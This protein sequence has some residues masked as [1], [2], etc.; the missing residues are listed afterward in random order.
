MRP[1][2]PHFRWFK[3]TRK[4]RNK[5]FYLLIFFVTSRKKYNAFEDFIV[6]NSAALLF[7][8]FAC[9]ICISLFDIIFLS[10]EFFKL[11][12]VEDFL[13]GKVW[14]PEKH[15]FGIL[16]VL[17]G[18]LYISLIAIAFAFPL[19][20]FSAVFL[21]VYSKRRV[22]NV[23]KTILEIIAGIPTI[24]LGFFASFFILP[25]LLA[26]CDTFG[27]QLSL[28]NAI[29]PGIAIGFMTIPYLTTLIDDAFRNV[30]DTLRYAGIALGISRAELMSQI[31]MRVAMPSIINSIIIAISRVL[32]ETMIVVISCGVMTIMNLNPLGPVTTIT[33]QIVHLLTGDASMGSPMVLSAFALSFALFVIVCVLNITSLFVNKYISRRFFT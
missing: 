19:S 12:N 8:C 21:A 32:G 7:L 10:A 20:F 27:I 29:V 1:K 15:Q 23:V 14:Q 18:T 16:P 33:V 25:R 26:L 4:A 2:C 17:I 31:L 5:F 6:R 13:F 30:P 9:I 11:Y 24:V 22:S 28:E 3:L